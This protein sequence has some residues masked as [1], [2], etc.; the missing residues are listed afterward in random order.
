[1][2]TYRGL[3]ISPEVLLMSPED[4]PVLMRSRSLTEIS[5][6]LLSSLEVFFYGHLVLHDDG[7]FLS[8]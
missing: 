6:V 7:I 2:R 5:G 1:M 8:L 3:L 4:L